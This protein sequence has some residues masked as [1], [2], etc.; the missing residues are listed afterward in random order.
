M[1]EINNQLRVLEWGGKK[2][3]IWTLACVF[4]AHAL[5]NAHVCKY[6]FRGKHALGAK[7]IDHLN[8][9]ESACARL[10]SCV[11]FV[12]F[13]YYIGCYRYAYAHQFRGKHTLGAKLIDHINHTESACARLCSRV[14]F[15]FDIKLAVIDMHM[16]TSSEVSTRSVQSSSITAGT[17]K[18]GT[19]ASSF[20]N[21][22]WESASAIDKKT[23]KKTHKN[24]CS[25]ARIRVVCKVC[26]AVFWLRL[27]AYIRLSNTHC[28]SSVYCECLLE[29]A[30]MLRGANVLVLHTFSII[31]SYILLDMYPKYVCC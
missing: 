21:L 15:F 16:R 7:L 4:I 10:C 5:F 6:Q 20:L 17:W 31:A 9:T 30:C 19:S 24:I 28:L 27:C 29:C 11:F 2:F 8:H 26:V 18:C 13:W 3:F 14:C 23:K 25:C 1:R 12:F 22:R